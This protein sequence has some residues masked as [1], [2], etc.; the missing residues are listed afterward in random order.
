MA[1]FKSFLYVYQWVG[2]FRTNLTS[3][4]SCLGWKSL[5]FWRLLKM[6]YPKS[7]WLIIMFPTNNGY[8]MGIL[9][10]SFSDTSQLSHSKYLYPPYYG[11]NWFQVTTEDRWTLGSFTLSHIDIGQAM[12]CDG[13]YGTASYLRTWG[14]PAMSTEIMA[15]GK[16]RWCICIHIYIYIYMSMCIYI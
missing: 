8:F 16:T 12:P 10:F 5:H 1:M 13:A 11:H 6:W 9:K 3:C 2:H 14:R 15:K 7:H 4:L